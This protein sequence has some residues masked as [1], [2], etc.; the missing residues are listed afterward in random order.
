MEW[1]I[2]EATGD[3]QVQQIQAQ[4]SVIGGVSYRPQQP[5]EYYVTQFG[6][7]VTNIQS[8]MKEI[9]VRTSKW[10]NMTKALVLV[11]MF[12]LLIQSH[13][14]KKTKEKLAET[15]K[16]RDRAAFI[17]F[18]FWFALIIGTAAFVASSWGMRRRHRRATPYPGRRRT[19]RRHTHRRRV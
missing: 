10:M 13:R 12:E 3:T 16:Y 6:Q 17:L 11:N 18:Y 19:Q 15:F 7:G 9:P 8:Q 2:G 1:L 4:E 14:E 5:S